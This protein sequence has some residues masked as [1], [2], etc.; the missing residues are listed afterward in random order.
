MSS[1]TLLSRLRLTPGNTSNILTSSHL[2]TH[3][4]T[5]VRLH[6][7]TPSHPHTLPPLSPSCSGFKVTSPEKKKIE[8][9]DAVQVCGSL[10]THLGSWFTGVSPGVQK[11]DEEEDE[12]SEDSGGSSNPSP[13]EYKDFLKTNF[14]SL[15]AEQA[16]AFFSQ[17]TSDPRDLRLSISARFFSQSGR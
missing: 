1:S 13:V 11:E 10:P 8:A 14:E 15:S 2:H 9:T 16:D 3:T 5:H 12:E 4:Y 17:P 6:I 7:S